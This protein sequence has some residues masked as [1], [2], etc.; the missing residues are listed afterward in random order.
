MHS[1]QDDPMEIPEGEADGDVLP[2]YPPP[3]E[4]IPEAAADAGEIPEAEAPAV[5]PSLSQRIAAQKEVVNT[6]KANAKAEK[7]SQDNLEKRKKTTYGQSQESRCRISYRNHCRTKT[8]PRQ[9]PSPRR[10]PR[11]NPR[12]CQRLRR[13][14]P[15]EPST[16]PPKCYVAVIIMQCCLVVQSLN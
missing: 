9:S 5:Q 2:V 11:R 10:S 14:Q 13:W 1:S 16:V 3:A 7:K 12:L 6:M 8:M 15:I 4:E